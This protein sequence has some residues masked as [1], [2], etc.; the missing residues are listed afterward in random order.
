MENKN[1][2]YNRAKFWQ[3][4]LFP[5]NNT[6]TNVYLF[7][8]G[9][10]SY[11]AVGVAGLLFP[12]ISIVITAMRIVDGFTDPIIGFFI[13]KTDGRFGKFRPAMIL[14]NV[15]L[16]VS[17]LL[18]VNT[19]HLFPEQL[20]LLV[21][22]FYYLLYVI[23][24]TFQTACTKA[25]QTCLTNDPK[26]RPTF[27]L[28]DGVYNIFLFA[29]F[30]VIVLNVMVP[31]HTTAT[32]EGLNSLSF[33]QEFALVS[34][35][36]SAVL[37]VLAVIGIMQKDRTEFFGLGKKAEKVQLKDYIDTLKNNRAIQMLIFAA[38]TD[39]LANT[40]ARNLT[41]MLIIFAITTGNESLPGSMGA[42]VALPS[43]LLLIFGI[44]YARKK[45]QK[46]ALV[47]S[48]WIALI[49]ALTVSAL[50]LFGP[51]STLSLS[52][53]NVFTIIFMLVY[54]IFAGSLSVAGNIVIPMIAD[55]ADYEVYRSGKYVPGMMGTLFSFVD[56]IVSSL[57]TT[58]VGLSLA[59]IG[60]VD[61]V[62]GMSTE[63]TQPLLYVGVFLFMGMPALGLIC[64]LI[65]MKFYPLTREKMDEIQ[66][67]IKRIKEQS[68]VDEQT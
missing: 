34:V 8:L 62:P 15:I 27:S 16:G 56:K 46:K 17:M 31:K 21:F 53:I 39:K 14:G 9:Y 58:I 45:G 28:Y 64:S 55:C 44:I 23:G 67:E 60:F 47:D 19:V 36:L 33:H 25:G 61:S 4:A 22:S 32:I 20:R 6:A 57:A 11:Y 26:Q 52:S 1:L 7:F 18:M 68:A 63:L 10:I 59:A 29:G 12:V 41:V 13:D 65:A 5:L 35:A 2:V 50:I 51:M 24:Y 38:S 43:M 30:P 42:I 40:T 37:T 66:G 48:T 3:M 54:I 49:S